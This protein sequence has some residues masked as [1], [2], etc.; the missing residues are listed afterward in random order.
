MLLGLAVAAFPGAAG[1]LETAQR[2]MVHGIWLNLILCFFNS[3]PRSAARRVAS[4]LLPP[5]AEGRE[6]YRD[7]QRFGYLPLFAL[8]FLFRPVMAF[9][10]TPA[11]TMMDL[12]AG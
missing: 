3:D 2:M 9:L 7:L 4:V 11:F 8:M 5:A 12:L 10:L 6:W 1:V